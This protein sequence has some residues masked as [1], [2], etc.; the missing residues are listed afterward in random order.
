MAKSF[1]IRTVKLRESSFHD[2]GCPR[3]GIRKQV[4]VDVQRNGRGGVADTA[5]D[6]QDVQALGYQLGYVGMPEAV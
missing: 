4:A 5:T 1:L 6:R 3:V 2:C